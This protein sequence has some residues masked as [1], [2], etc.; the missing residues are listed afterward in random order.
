MNGM[1]AKIYEDILNKLNISCYH[2]P[3][4]CVCTEDCKKGIGFFLNCILC[5]KYKK[6]CLKLACPY[7]PERVLIKEKM[8]SMPDEELPLHIQKDD[9]FYKL[10]KYRLSGVDPFEPTPP[11]IPIGDI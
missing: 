10:A 3:V 1:E 9:I 7:I 5:R 4:P 8:S 6:L 2:C 11:S